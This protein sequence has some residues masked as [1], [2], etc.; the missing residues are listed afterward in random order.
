ME[1]ESS[2]IERLLRQARLAKTGPRIIPL[3]PTLTR[4][5]GSLLR[6]FSGHVDSV[7]K[8][9][10]TPD[11]RFAISASGEEELSIKIWDLSDGTERQT[12]TGHKDYISNLFVTPDSRHLVWASGYDNELRIYDLKNWV[13][14]PAQLGHG[15][16]YAITPGGNRI[17]TSAFN[18][19]TIRLWDW[20]KGIEESTLFE[21]PTG[22]EYS[23]LKLIKGYAGIVKTVDVMSD[24]R[25]AIAGFDDGTLRVWDLLTFGAERQV[26]HAHD[27]P[28]TKV[29]LSPDGRRVIS[30][31]K[32]I[33]KIWDL[34]KGL[35]PFPMLDETITLSGHNEHI[36]DLAVTPDSQFV[37]SA[38]DDMTLKV[39]DLTSGNEVCTLSGHVDGISGIAVHPDGQRVLSASYDKTLKE[40][41]ITK[42]DLDSSTGEKELPAHR[43]NVCA[44]SVLPDGHHAIS[45]S[46]DKMLKVWDLKNIREVHTY[47]LSHTKSV[48]DAVVMP[49][50]K[51]VLTGSADGTLRMLDLGI[52]E[53]IFSLTGHRRPVLCV[54]VTPDGR[55]AI[56]GS[57][58][59]TLKVW[60]LESKTCLH[61][62]IGH[63]DWISGLAAL[64]DSLSVISASDDSTLKLWDLNS[65]KELLTLEGHTDKVYAVAALPEERVI[66]ASKDTT[67]KV[68]DLRKRT[69]EMT[70]KGHTAP[71]TGLAVSHDGQRAVSASGDA[72]L[73]VWDLNAMKNIASFG[74]DGPIIRCAIA[75]DGETII[76]GEASGR[77]HFLQL[78]AF[79]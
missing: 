28:I 60:N 21:G 39:W 8:I 16:V 51:R 25:H 5:G 55:L 58:D 66:S 3:K 2:D 59:F 4:P 37:I 43:R 18:D 47:T 42:D 31:S 19:Y 40:W 61:T 38:S 65:G 20:T 49:D 62:L 22:K 17:I 63:R 1:S 10:V 29:K 32:S 9:A 78:D 41:A 53:E 46:F 74:G 71:V 48:Y 12:I 11:G 6:T 64:P 23:Q 67:L 73:K 68:W 75:P 24:N 70:L 7:L 44:V 33:I 56:S 26:V 77:V 14:L 79:D 72:S 69:V 27:K 13:E 76:A 15:T 54:G 36:Y 52:G 50:G 45:A 35:A 57:E 34:T 30:S